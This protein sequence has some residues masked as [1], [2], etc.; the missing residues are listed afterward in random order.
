[1]WPVIH[2]MFNNSPLSQSNRYCFNDGYH[3]SHHLNPRRHWRDHPVSFLKAKHQYQKEHALVFHNIDYLMITVKLL[4]KDYDHL[5]R[6]LVPIGE[7]VGM[8]H[9]DL[10]ALLRTKTRKFTNQDIE[11]KFKLGYVSKYIMR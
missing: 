5:A 1:M 8:S 10:V 9:E 11:R 2:A 6:C 4:Q 3:T 7:Q